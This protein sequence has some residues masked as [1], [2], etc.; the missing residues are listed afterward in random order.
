MFQ[1]KEGEGG[2]F[3]VNE[4][5]LKWAEESDV[6]LCNIFFEQLVKER[7]ELMGDKKY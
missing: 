4:R 6:E 2:R 3:N 7:E 5:F 1:Q